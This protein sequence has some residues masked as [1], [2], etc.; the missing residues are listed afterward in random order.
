MT[1][2]KQIAWLDSVIEV[3]TL[4]CEPKESLQE[5]RDTLERLNAENVKLR[6]FA[7]RWINRMRGFGECEAEWMRGEFLDAIKAVEDG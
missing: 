1:V 2:E 6:E 3:F 5:V 7:N 4:P